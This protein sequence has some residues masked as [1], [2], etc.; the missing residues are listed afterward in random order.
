MTTSSPTK[1]RRKKLS[2]YW[3]RTGR[4]SSRKRAKRLLRVVA[5]LRSR[6]EKGFP[7]LCGRGN[8]QSGATARMTASINPT[9]L[10]DRVGAQTPLARRQAC[11]AACRI[12]ASRGCSLRLPL[13]LLLAINI[14]PLIWMIRLSFTSYQPNRPNVPLGLSASTIIV[15]ILTDEDIWQACKRPRILSSRQSCYRS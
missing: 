11:A 4:K 9:P 6:S 3:S 10:V 14:F 12:A 13:L 8:R 15:D 5:F 1:A 7:G 2:I